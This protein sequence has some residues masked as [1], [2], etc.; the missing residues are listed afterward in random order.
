MTCSQCKQWCHEEHCT[1]TTPS[2]TCVCVCD[3]ELKN[4]LKHVF[5]N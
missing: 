3:I 5:Y 1:V 2:V 4:D